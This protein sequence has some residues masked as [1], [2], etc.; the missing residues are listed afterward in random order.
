MTGGAVR[1]VQTLDPGPWGPTQ[2]HRLARR[3]LGPTGIR[4]LAFSPPLKITPATLLP[5]ALG[6]SPLLLGG[7][8]SYVS[9]T[10]G[11]LNDFQVGRLASS[12]EAFSDVDRTESE[13]LSGA[14][15]GTV[16]LAAG[17]WEAAI[18]LF[19]R[20]AKA[21]QDLEE[22][23]AVGADKLS[24]GV[25]SWVLNDTA[26][27]YYGEGFERVYVHASM[28]L[29]YLAQG[30]LNDVYVEARLANELLESEEELY[31]K[32]YAAGGL[33]HFVSAIAYELL[34]ELDQAYIDYARMA[35]KGVGTGV[36]GPALLRLAKLL[37]RDDDMP[38]WRERFGDPLELPPDAASVVLIAGVG[39][40]PFKV[41]SSL[42]IPGHSGVVSVAV[43]GYAHRPQPVTELLLFDSAT[44]SSVLTDVLERVDEIAPANLEDRL[45]WTA[46]KSITRGLAKRELTRTLEDE[47]GVTGRLVGDL[48][49]VVSERADLRS[50]TT[51][52]ASWQAARMWVP[53]GEVAPI[54]EAVGGQRIELGRFVLEPGETMIILARNVGTNLYVHAIGGAPVVPTSA[55]TP[56][57][58]SSI[59]SSSQPDSAGTNHDSSYL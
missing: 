35:E 27:T 48:F 34:G 53:P 39:L 12:Q 13:F 9:R 58:D 52:P 10:A 32:E 21:S 7:C 22:R 8:A 47:A 18:A 31:D 45:L 17:D 29:A 38:R 5:L 19:E 46:A 54:V 4:S 15:A 6:A 33:G 3:S 51:L 16:A 42:V 30:R 56:M 43:P 41:E 28:A 40:A 57:M 26:K 2:I 23:G 25:G 55:S 20:A 50:W 24:E 11:A 49:S 37:G 59:N 1:M 44:G 36:A 14:E